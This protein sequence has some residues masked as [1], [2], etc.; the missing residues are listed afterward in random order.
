MLD[1]AM[2]APGESNDEYRPEELRIVGLV[3]QTGSS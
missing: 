3:Q 1:A 2:L